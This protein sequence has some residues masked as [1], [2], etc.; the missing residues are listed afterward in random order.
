M[1]IALTL[2]SSELWTVAGTLVTLTGTG[3]ALY[4]ARSARE[5]AV[6]AKE[7]VALAK[8]QAVQAREANKLTKLSRHA[9]AGQLYVEEAS[10]SSFLV[11]NPMNHTVHNIVVSCEGMANSEAYIKR[12]S[13]NSS[14]KFALSKPA[15]YLDSVTLEWTNQKGE[16]SHLRLG[17]YDIWGHIEK[18]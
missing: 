18:R 16:T 15:V 3:I 9:S 12:L 10:E 1:D 2:N 5:S 11:T 4:Q 8:E 17:S 13:P 6:L 14:E 7:Q